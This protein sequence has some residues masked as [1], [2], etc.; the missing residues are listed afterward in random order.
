M[1]QRICRVVLGFNGSFCLN[2]ESLLYNVAGCQHHLDRFTWRHDSI[3]NFI[4]DPLQPIIINDCSSLYADVNGFLSP[5]ILT[6]DNRPDLLFL[7][8]SQCLGYIL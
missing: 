1:H 6:G 4:A 7:L 3:L 5:S 8:Q 2:P